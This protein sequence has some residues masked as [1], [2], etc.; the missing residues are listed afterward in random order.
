MSSRSS[1]RSRGTSP[2]IS[3]QSPALR[4]LLDL[5]SFQAAQGIEHARW[6]R[7][8]RLS[9]SR[10]QRL[11]EN[12]NAIIFGADLQQFIFYVTA[13]RYP[14]SGRE[15]HL[16][17]LSPFVIINLVIAA[18]SLT[19]FPHWIIFSS[20]F[21]LSHNI[22]CIGDFAISNFVSKA[23][24]RIYTYDETETKMSYFYVET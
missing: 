19:L 17:T 24:G 14:V 11:I 7:L 21:L 9:D 2:R 12:A 15:V 4:A 1:R 23:G 3:T 10:S 18:I 5:V 20:C 13:N 6:F 8:A 22:M 16:L